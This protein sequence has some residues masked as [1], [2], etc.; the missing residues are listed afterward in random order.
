MSK[1][2]NPNLKKELIKTA[3]K[4]V[5]NSIY[6]RTTRVGGVAATGVRKKIANLIKKAT[7]S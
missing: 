3:T 6:K 7:E 5:V 2:K 1:E 4:A